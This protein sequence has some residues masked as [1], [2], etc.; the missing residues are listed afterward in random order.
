MLIRKKVELLALV[1]YGSYPAVVCIPEML[2]A[3][4][5]GLSAEV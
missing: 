1:L 4:M 2:R 3:V 5:A